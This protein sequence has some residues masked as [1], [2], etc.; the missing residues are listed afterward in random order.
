MTGK[1]FINKYTPKMGLICRSVLVMEEVYA[2]EKFFLDLAFDSKTCN[3]VLTASKMGGHP[4]DRLL[5]LYPDAIRRH[6]IDVTKG[7]D[8]AELAVRIAE[9]FGC[10]NQTVRL[11]TILKNFYNCFIERDCLS[12]T[13]NPIVLTAEN[14]L[15]VLGCKLEIDDSAIYRQAELFSMLDYSQMP[16]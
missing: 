4:L 7:I 12:L 10:P 11:R 3:P 5:T 6:Q 2:S 13:L 8:S 15:T 16:P 1:H 14:D 9:D